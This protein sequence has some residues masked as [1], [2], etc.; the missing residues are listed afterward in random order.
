MEHVQRENIPASE[1]AFVFIIQLVILSIFVR[2][3]YNDNKNKALFLIF[4]RQVHIM[5]NR[6]V[7]WRLSQVL[8]I[9]SKMKY[10]K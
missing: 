4:N 8:S 5:S 9:H 1:Y 2:H 3:Y 7:F 10:D 6:K